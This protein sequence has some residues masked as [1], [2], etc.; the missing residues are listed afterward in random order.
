VEQDVTRHGYGFRFTL[1]ALIGGLVFIA[2][3][4]LQVALV[5]YANIGADW[6]YAAQAFFS[7]CRTCSIDT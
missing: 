7:I 6:A 5:R 3:L 4:A 2:G 1:F